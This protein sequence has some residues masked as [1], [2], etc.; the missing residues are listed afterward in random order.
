M[1]V[2]LPV[3]GILAL[4]LSVVSCNAAK[5]AA[6]NLEDELTDEEPYTAVDGEEAT[7][8]FHDSPGQS[9]MDPAALSKAMDLAQ[10]ESS[11]E[12]LALHGLFL[13]D[14]DEEIAS[15]DE[16][17]IKLLKAGSLDKE[18]EPDPEQHTKRGQSEE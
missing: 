2:R 7:Q 10:Q 15:A 8:F 17:T 18:A 1:I 16:A 12:V 9:E 4:G 6:K 11:N 5:N 14:S 13:A 3:L